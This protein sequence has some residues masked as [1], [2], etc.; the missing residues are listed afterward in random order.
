MLLP[1]FPKAILPQE[2]KRNPPATENFLASD[3]LAII[4]GILSKFDT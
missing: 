4:Y 3:Y 2:K 1:L